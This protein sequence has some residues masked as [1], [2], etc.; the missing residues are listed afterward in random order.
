[1]FYQKKLFKKNC[2]FKLKASHV[3]EQFMLHAYSYGHS[4]RLVSELNA[5]NIHY[6]YW[7][8]PILILK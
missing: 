1:M 4:F 8:L 2:E 5:T 6:S 3:L 7:R